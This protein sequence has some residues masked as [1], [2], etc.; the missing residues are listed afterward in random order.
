MLS[1]RL[2]SSPNCDCCWFYAVGNQKLDT[3]HLPIA[4]RPTYHRAVTGE[5]K[6]S[7]TER[8]WKIAQWNCRLRL[9]TGQC[10]VACDWTG[11]SHWGIRLQAQLEQVR[12]LHTGTGGSRWAFIMSIESNKTSFPRFAYSWWGI[13]SLNPEGSW[14][15]KPPYLHKII[16]FQ[17]YNF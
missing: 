9:T 1:Y 14:G 3:A 2:C 13:W 11:A 12:V 17:P 7:I 8:S 16:S 5:V 4:F 15:K 10:S 6:E